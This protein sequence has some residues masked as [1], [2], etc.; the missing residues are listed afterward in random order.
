MS[1]KVAQHLFSL[2]EFPSFQVY[3][4]QKQ[5]DTSSKQISRSMRA[6]KARAWCH[7]YSWDLTPATLA[8]TFLEYQHE[9]L[10]RIKLVTL[11][12]EKNK[13]TNKHPTTSTPTLCLLQQKDRTGESEICNSIWMITEGMSQPHI[14]TA[15][16]V[17]VSHTT[18][19]LSIIHFYLFY[20]IGVA[21]TESSYKNKVN[22]PLS[23]AKLCSW[24]LLCNPCNCESPKQLPDH[25]IHRQ[26][27]LDLHVFLRNQGSSSS[28][29]VHH[30]KSK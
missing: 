9:S 10:K 7:R 14:A 11:R 8:S 15:Y 27:L 26:G 1:R 23:L 4:A 25:N 12:E 16:F 6:A 2:E 3:A 22:A 29:C 28:Y 13:Q 24:T 21:K 30:Q 17:C 19:S 18:L 5:L 20:S